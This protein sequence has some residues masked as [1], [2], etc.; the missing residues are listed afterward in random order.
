MTVA[1]LGLFAMHGLSGH[2]TSHHLGDHLG[3]HLSMVGHEQVVLTAPAAASAAEAP[4]GH[5]EPGIVGLC[6]AVLV[7]AVLFFAAG[8]RR[9]I[10]SLPPWASWAERRWSV[11]AGRDRDPPDLIHLSIQ[12][13]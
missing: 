4:S 5:S 8:R 11:G 10:G 13:C 6:L 1:L 9:L 3:D 12:R 7:A 2:G